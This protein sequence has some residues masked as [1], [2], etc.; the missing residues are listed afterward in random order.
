ML[1]YNDHPFI[2]ELYQGF[3]IYSVKRLN[4]LAQRYDAGSEYAELII[5]N[6]DPIEHP[7]DQ[8]LSLFQQAD[9]NICECELISK[10]ESL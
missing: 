8:Q 2:R 9:E 6:Y 5:T 1:S 10:G 4:N 7:K 3:W